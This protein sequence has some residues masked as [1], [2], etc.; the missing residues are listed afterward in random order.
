M[1]EPEDKRILVRL[2]GELADQLNIIAGRERR[3][4]NAQIVYML[5][6]SVASYQR[7]KEKEAQEEPEER[8]RPALL[9]A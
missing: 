6:R 3:S 1:E 4:L 5:E 2:P 7:R 8:Y 9:A